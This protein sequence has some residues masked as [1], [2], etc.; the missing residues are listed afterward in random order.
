MKKNLL[1]SVF[2]FIFTF[3][4]TQERSFKDITSITKNA[5]GLYDVVCGDSTQEVLTQHDIM[6]DNLCPHLTYDESRVDILFVVD[7]S[8]SMSPLQKKLAAHVGLMVE[9][10]NLRGDDYRIAVTTTD[11][12]GKSTSFVNNSGYDVLD[13]NTPNLKEAFEKN[14]T[15]GTNGSGT[16]QGFKQAEVALTTYMSGNFYRKHSKLHIVFFGDEGDQ[17]Q[18]SAQTFK[19]FLDNYTGSGAGLQK[20][21]ITAVNI[22]TQSCRSEYPNGAPL[23]DKEVELVQLTGGKSISL[24]DKVYDLF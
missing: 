22:F 6:T 24:C 7:D 5:S 1:L 20:Y 18:Y 4:G 15:V 23:A 17:S 3:A 13:K 2:V 10:L 16:E 9:K 19:S 12:T 14:V 11:S 21:E 8:G